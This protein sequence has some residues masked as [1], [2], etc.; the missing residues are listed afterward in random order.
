MLE[1]FIVDVANLWLALFGKQY[2]HFKVLRR[3]NDMDS[4]EIGLDGRPC[5]YVK[6]AE[7]FYSPLL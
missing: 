3:L 6:L 7:D 2:G 4:E 5:P 1:K